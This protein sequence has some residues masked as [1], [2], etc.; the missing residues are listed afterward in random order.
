MAKAKS[1]ESKAQFQARVT[2]DNARAASVPVGAT[3][4]DSIIGVTYRNDGPTGKQSPDGWDLYNIWD[5]D[6]KVTAT[7][8]SALLTG[9]TR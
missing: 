7:W 8:S 4:Y 5:T 9:F 3:Y 2:A 1:R 6:W